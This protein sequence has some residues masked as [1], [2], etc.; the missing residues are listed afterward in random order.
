MV[1]AEVAVSPGTHRGPLVT[2][3]T[4]LFCWRTRWIQ[5]NHEGYP[6]TC[7]PSQKVKIKGDPAMPFFEENSQKRV[8]F[9]CSQKLKELDNNRI[10]GVWLEHF[11]LLFVLYARVLP[12][13]S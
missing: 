6:Q 8:T 10:S 5:I 13:A 9:H 4:R 12:R 11:S 3:L 2:G 1:I 7:E